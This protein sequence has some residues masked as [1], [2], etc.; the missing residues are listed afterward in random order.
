MARIPFARQSYVDESA[1]LSSQR[2]VNL[3]AELHAGD[4]RGTPVG[5]NALVVR[6]TPGL[7]DYC[8]LEVGPVYAL[9]RQ[10]TEVFAISGTAAYRIGPGNTVTWLGNVDASGDL[11][12]STIACSPDKVVFCVP[13][14]TYVWD[15]FTGVFEQFLTPAVTGV[16]SVEVMN[17]Y[18]VYVEM[19]ARGQFYVSKL[20]EPKN[21]SALDFATAE[22]NPDYLFRTVAFASALW[23]FGANTVEVWQPSSSVNLPFEPMSGG[24]LPIGC[25]SMQSIAIV[26]NAIYWLADDLAVYRA[27]GYQKE[28]ISTLP[29]D[30]LLT[31]IGTDQSHLAFGFAINHSG[32]RQYVLS[33]PGL[34]SAWVY[35]ADTELW[36]ERQSGDGLLWYAQCGLNLDRLMLV[37]SRIDGRVWRMTNGTGQEGGATVKRQA[38][39]P[40]LYKDGKRMFMSR[41]ELEIDAGASSASPLLLDYSDD[42]G[43]TFSNQRAATTG[44]A[45]AYRTRL[46]WH[47]LGSF[48][49][50]TLRVTMPEGPRITIFGA[51]ADVAEGVH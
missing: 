22:S 20:N 45:G 7:V 17:G 19:T 34:S 42:G 12:R 32:H 16:Q 47:R 23:F 1:P 36:H 29:L 38:V 40:P 41:L 33:V 51:L 9:R 37:G 27:R 25:R 46:N 35:D 39:L 3:M 11:K 43:R 14:H 28:K 31:A 6:S 5:D 15:F 8:T 13:P 44:N 18:F 26:D 4:A 10:R 21:I 2:L 24:Q 30:R 49:Q 50:R 48:R